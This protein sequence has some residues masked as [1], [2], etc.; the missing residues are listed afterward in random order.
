M[1]RWARCV[2]VVWCVLTMLCGRVSAQ[3][4]DF[5]Y[6]AYKFYKD[7]EPLLVSL[8]DTMRLVL[9]KAGYVA[10]VA[11]RSEYALR[12]LN[13][14]SMG[15][16]DV[17]GYM[18]GNQHID[19]TTARLL[20]QLRVYNEL[21]RGN[22]SRGLYS[23]K[24]FD[25]NNRLYRGASLRAEL[26]GRGYSGG[27][28][29]YAGYKPE[30]NGVLL[31][32]G[33][34]FRH[35]VRVAGGDDLYVAGVSA[36]I[37]DISFGATWSD[38][39]SNL[40]I[41]AL[42]PCS[43]RGLR[44]ASAE[45]C[46]SLVGDR[47]YNPLWGI[48]NGELRNSRVATLMRPEA[49]VSWDYKLTVSTTMRLTA[50]V[51]YAAEGVTS[52]A[53]FNASTPLPDNYHYLPSYYDYPADAKYV[54]DAWLRNDLRYTQVDWAGMRHTNA[55][56]LDGHARY[57]VESRKEDIANGDVV[58]AFDTKL[59]GV[60]ATY[61]LRLGGANYHRYKVLDD[62]LGATHI[63]DLD[64]YM[65][66]DATHYNGTKN[67][68][69]GDDLVVE[70]G[71]TFGYDYALRRMKSD[72]FARLEWEYGDM[73]FAANANVGSEHISRKGR[74]EKELF[75]GAGSYGRSQSVDLFPYAFT[76]AWSYIVDNQTF[77]ASVLA[78]GESPEIDNLFFN[79]EYNNRVVE[80][81]T[82]AKRHAARF[83]YAIV[84]N[85]ALRISALLYANSYDDGC[86]VVRYYDDLSGIYSNAIVKGI[87]WLGY[88]I[89]LCAEV[90]WNGMLSSNFRAIAS[91]Y[92]YAD[93]ARLS[94]Y[95]NRDN[96]LIAHSDVLIKG[97]HRGGA[98][99]VGYGD[100]SFRYDGWM[101]T[102]S[103]SCCDG[104]YLSPSFIPRSERVQSFAT[105]EE[106][107]SA[108]AYQRDLPSATVVDVSLSKRLKLKSGT[109][110]SAT[111]TIKNL[112]GG[113]WVAS[114]YE[115]NRVR[116]V[117]NDY[118]SRLFKS[119]EMVSY[120]Y[121]RMLNLTLNL[122]F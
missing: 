23:T 94:L 93:N 110:L 59:R 46:Y 30:Y 120:S 1:A 92:R 50:D 24:V 76:L 87:S 103:L 43:R 91:S 2:A 95:S 105:S 72:V 44:R 108:L 52:L 9:P 36:N 17:V 117:A 40:N 42:L 85:T 104:G 79:P 74:F 100:L 39:R 67:N 113:S 65:V 89:D 12:V 116:C 70:Q 106:V 109:S 114:G 5:D 31:K 112:L 75:R 27:V 53:W 62:L 48:D 122:W 80:N 7:E 28:T 99:L 96:S 119:A 81:L 71:D 54:T 118:Y 86:E 63:L 77:G 101:A 68:L 34:A 16:R 61:G 121:P 102:A 60:D 66:D 64:Y 6:R 83:S 78:S 4:V 8:E 22:I 11:R 55:L 51:Y 97:C 45:E 90:S 47:L 58:L 33:W 37:F 21:D 26:I 38:R 35:A 49:L 10:D 3:E 115:S 57:V 18:L 111:V 14:R 15:E 32:D 84:P 73:R 98:E 88:G 69:R 20:S 41:F 25:P 56:Q 107:R 82:T 19:Y 13:Y 29:Y